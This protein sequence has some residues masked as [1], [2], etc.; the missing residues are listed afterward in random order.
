MNM[1]EFSNKIP[2]EQLSIIF[3]DFFDEHIAVYG[4]LKET[5]FNSINILT[6]QKSSIM[7]SVKLLKDADKEK[8]SSHISNLKLSAYGKVYT[9]SVYINGDLLC[10]TISK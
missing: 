5:E 1:L 2:S 4:A 6:E 9:P 10:I 8:L 3:K 7:Y